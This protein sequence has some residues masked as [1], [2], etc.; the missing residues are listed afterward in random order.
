M[1]LI[2]AIT[3]AKTPRARRSTSAANLRAPGSAAVADRIA[4]AIV[5]IRK[6]TPLTGAPGLALR[7]AVQRRKNLRALG[8]ARI[9]P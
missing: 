9:S 8:R 3:D 1:S 4:N 2:R 7:G 5:R 6:E